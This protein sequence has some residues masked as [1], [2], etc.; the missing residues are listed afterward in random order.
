MGARGVRVL[1]SDGVVEGDVA[2]GDIV[3]FKKPLIRLQEA[4][5]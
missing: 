3:Q 5:L 4:T 2:S 1:V